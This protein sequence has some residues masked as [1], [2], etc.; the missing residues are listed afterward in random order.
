MSR[1]RPVKK[2]LVGLLV[3]PA[4]ALSPD[5]SAQQARTPAAPTPPAPDTPAAPSTAP[6]TT[7]QVTTV[8]GSRPSDDFQPPATSLE[9]LG[10]DPHDIPQSITVINKALME[11]QGVTSLQ[12]AVRNIPGVTLGAAEGSTI[13]NNIYLNGFSARTDLYIDGMRDPAQYYRDTFDLEQI[14]VLMGPS[15]MLFGRGSTGGVINQVMKKPTLTKKI[16]LSAAGSTNVYTRETADLNLP[17]SE[18]SAV[19]VNMMFQDGKASSRQQT[20]VQDFGFAPSYKFGIG[21]PT[22]VTLYGLL[23]VNHDHVDYGLPALN[24]Y[25][26]NVSPNLAYG[27]SNDHTDQMIAMTGATLNHKFNDGL[28]LRNQTQFNYVNTNVVETAPQSVG[29]VSST[30]VF[31]ALAAGTPGGAGANLWVRQQSHDR[32]IYDI[33]VNNQTELTADFNTGPVKHK[34]LSGFDMGL[35]SYYNQ[36]YYR[37]GSCNGTALNAAGATT[38]YVGCTSLLAPGGGNSPANVPEL[39]GNLATGYA[40]FGGIYVNDTIEIIPEV[41]LVAGLRY[42]IY[43]SQIGNSLNQYNTA[44]N[45]TAA[46]LAETDYYL[47]YRGGIIFQPTKEQTY[48]IST[49]TS[50][51][52]SLEQLVTTTGTNSQTVPPTTNTAY[53]A[54]VKFDIFNE[55]LSLAGAVF[56]IEQDNAR[57][58]NGDGT[59]TAAGTILVKGVRVGA[60]GRLTD[61]WQ[62]FAGYAYLDARITNGIGAGTQGMI[63][64]N[65][66]TDSATVWTTYAIGK[67]WEVGGGATYT[68]LRFANNT[69]TTAVPAGYHIDVTAAYKMEKADLRLNIFNLTDTTYYEQ[70]MASDGG[71]TVPYTGLTAMLTLAY[72][73]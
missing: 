10:G 63:P 33:T 62:V 59:V 5:V 8:T 55:M 41:K 69:D 43:S 46:Y 44:G 14:E 32:N 19:R 54:G 34:L 52:P 40:T 26:A 39:P 66:P 12:S 60:V 9:R 11:S 37:N 15:S 23:Q 7:M 50:F 13:G 51:N 38:G 30:G 36:N 25:P 49:S 1:R 27:F 67:S 64:Q 3:A 2:A 45:T 72:H 21:T 58:T 29:T 16:D 4:A 6:T 70:A 68:G 28:K 57:T 24:R 73:L 47:S 31:T 71:R 18:T 35:E 61:A 48:Y 42:D 20:E 65:T 17:M 53:E 56:Q 22:E